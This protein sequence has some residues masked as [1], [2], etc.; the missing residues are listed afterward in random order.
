[1]NRINASRFSIIKKTNKQGDM[2]VFVCGRARYSNVD[3]RENIA[4]EMTFGLR[5][6]GQ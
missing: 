5:L 6:E 2:T 3:G 1:M 4:G